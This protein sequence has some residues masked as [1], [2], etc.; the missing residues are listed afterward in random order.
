MARLLLV[1]L[2]LVAGPAAAAG[3]PGTLEPEWVHLRDEK[4]VRLEA[5]RAGRT[6]A[7]RAE[8]AN[9]ALGEALGGERRGRGPSPT[10]RRWSSTSARSPSSP[11][12]PPTPGPP[13]P[14]RWR[15]TPRA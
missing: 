13:G 12:T 10:A 11:S 1:A 7:Q 14:R 9:R 3:G 2:L 5:P 4:I 15:P 6:A 8:E